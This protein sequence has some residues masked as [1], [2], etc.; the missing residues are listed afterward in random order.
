MTCTH[1]TGILELVAQAGEE[2][3][4]DDETEIMR[5]HY[6]PAAFAADKAP[7]QHENL[8]ALLPSGLH[9][10]ERASVI[11]TLIGNW[12]SNFSVPEG[13]LA[14][15]ASSN[16]F[17]STAG[18]MAFT[19]LGKL[20]AT[21]MWEFTHSVAKVLVRSGGGLGYSQYAGS[22]QRAELRSGFCAGPLSFPLTPW[23]RPHF[24][25]VGQGQSVA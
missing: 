5:V 24:C 16:Q 9:I 7:R 20:C 3:L 13:P 12:G 10:L 14:N 11:F 22:S 17:S 25:A 23:F 2:K 6:V 18:V 21:L 8:T 15:T 1:A 4:D 19:L